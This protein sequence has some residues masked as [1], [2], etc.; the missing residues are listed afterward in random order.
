LWQRNWRDNHKKRE[1]Q[2]QQQQ[3]EQKQQSGDG[4]RVQRPPLTRLG[5]MRGALFNPASEFDLFTRGILHQMGSMIS[6]EIIRSPE[7]FSSHVTVMSPLT[8]TSSDLRELF[9]IAPRAPAARMIFND[10]RL[11][12]VVRNNQN[13]NSSS[14]AS[15]SASTSV[16]NPFQSGH[17]AARWRD[18]FRANDNINASAEAMRSL[19]DRSLYDTQPS[20]LRNGGSTLITLSS[21]PT[22]QEADTCTICLDE[23]RTQTWA[24]YPC[25]KNFAHLSCAKKWLTDKATC[26]MCRVPIP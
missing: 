23:D 7:G 11:D 8:R 6:S 15:A 5:G 25:C 17:A 4:G 16:L 18:L 19:L 13:H 20:N 12:A 2:Q 21:P 26:P 1:Q 10:A 22:T 3:Q 14:P 9:D 24:Q